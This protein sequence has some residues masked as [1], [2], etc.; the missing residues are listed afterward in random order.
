MV[1]LCYILV[2]HCN[3]CILVFFIKISIFNYWHKKKIKYS[4]IK[5]WMVN[6]NTFTSIQTEN[7]ICK[8]KLK[9][10]YDNKCIKVNRVLYHSVHSAT[11]LLCFRI[12]ILCTLW[13]FFLL[14]SEKGHNLIHTTIR[15][16]ITNTGKHNQHTFKTCD[17]IN[18]KW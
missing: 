2:W 1:T 16:V 14:I 3:W 6:L 15:M 8:L 17:Q 18:W 10:K 7:K 11:I 13:Y 9:G 4:W 12:L 5:S